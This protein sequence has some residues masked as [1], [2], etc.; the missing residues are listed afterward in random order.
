M[1]PRNDTWILEDADK[2]SM[3]PE[4]PLC[5][6][7][8]LIP[9]VYPLCSLCS[10][11]VRD[12]RAWALGHEEHLELPQ[13]AQVACMPLLLAGL[14]VGALEEASIRTVNPTGIVC[15]LFDPPGPCLLPH[16]INGKA[17]RVQVQIQVEMQI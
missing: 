13:N 12:R 1:A 16:I 6:S 10:R 15:H 2:G 7:N 9:C 14:C 4:G 5:Y 8:L 17:Q 11:H 3:R